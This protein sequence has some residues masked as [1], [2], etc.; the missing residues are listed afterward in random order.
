MLDRAEAAQ[1]LQIVDIDMPVV[2]L[3]AAPAQQIA[4]HVLARPLRAAGRGYRDKILCRGKLRVKTGVD[5]VENPL[6]G[7]DGVHFRHLSSRCRFQ[8]RIRANRLGYSGGEISRPMETRMPAN[9]NILYL[10][11]GALIVAVG[12]LGYNLYQTKKEPEG[13]QINVG[14]NGLK[15]QNK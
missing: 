7:I 10:I 6:L 12:V 14:P 9:R 5:G 8:N 15:I 13:L 1:I 3:V 4:D 2:D 11:V